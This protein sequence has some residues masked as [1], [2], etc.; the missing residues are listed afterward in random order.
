MVFPVS[1][2]SPCHDAILTLNRDNW[3]VPLQYVATLPA[4]VQKILDAEV[5]SSEPDTLCPY[6]KWY[7]LENRDGSAIDPAV[8]TYDELAQTI[9][10]Q[11]D[12]PN[13]IR[14]HPLTLRFAYQWH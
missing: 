8:F 12:D 4:Y 6:K 3:P 7:H 11:T 9:T 1:L 2:K 10:T 13:M 14:V 5:M